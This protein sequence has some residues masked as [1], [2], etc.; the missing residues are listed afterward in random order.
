LPNLEQLK[1]NLT[2]ISDNGL[3]SLEALSR[4]NYLELYGTRV[5][6]RGL[7]KFNEDRPGVEV[8]ITQNF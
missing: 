4:L 2:E 7:A 5:T 8:V 6:L 1:L 3:L